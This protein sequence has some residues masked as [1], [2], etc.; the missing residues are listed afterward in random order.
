[1]PRPGPHILLAAVLMAAVV[2]VNAF[3]VDGALGRWAAGRLLAPIASRTGWLHGY[4]RA[5]A[6][7][8][9][10]VARALALDEREVRIQAR[11]AEADQLR[12]DLAAAR[13]AAGIRDRAGGEPLEAGVFA[14]P[15]LGGIRELVVNRGARDWI[16]AGDVVTTP[17]GALV[18]VIRDAADDHAAVRAVGDV[19]LEITAR[20]ADT[21]IT[22]LVRTDPREGLVMDLV[23]KEEPVR[24]GQVV[25]TSGND[26]FPAALVI[27]TVRSVDAA[28][29]TLFATV[30]VDAATPPAYAGPVLILRLR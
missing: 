3:L 21:D 24:E 6:N 26:R 2:A 29:T 4:V 11:E 1:M 13:A 14:W 15:R 23:G 9:D 17:A 22:G 7:R 28:A 16:S 8:H 5:L 25:V 18:G 27:G 30:R 19:G 10:D 20:I 12:R